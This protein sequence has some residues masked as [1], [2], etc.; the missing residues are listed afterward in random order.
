[1][2]NVLVTP[3]GTVYAPGKNLWRSDDHGQTWRK[4]TD[5]NDWQIVGLAVKDSD[6]KTLWLSRATWGQNAAG[7]IYQTTDGGRTWTDITSNIPY[8]KPLVLRY[9]PA[10]NEL[11]AAG[12]GIYKL[13]LTAP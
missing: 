3:K 10:S 8:R 2:F 9:N 6:E 5:F 1:M 11:W 13:P 7:G 12:V 4:L